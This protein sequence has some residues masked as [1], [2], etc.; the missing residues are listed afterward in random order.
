[1][2]SNRTVAQSKPLA[3]SLVFAYFVTMVIFLWSKYMKTLP[4]GA[5]KAQCLKLMD[6]VQRSR[7][8]IVITKYGKPVALLAP[9]AQE[10][11]SIFGCMKGSATIK[12]DIVE[13]FPASD[14]EALL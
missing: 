10:E 5:F 1:M 9:I 3:H 7:E 2:R 13:P 8:P 6:D 14:W 12:G 4:A 11:H